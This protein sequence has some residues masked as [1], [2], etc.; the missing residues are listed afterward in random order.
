MRTASRAMPTRGVITYLA[1]ERHSSYGRDSIELLKVSVTSLFRYYNSHARD[2]MIFFH[3]GVSLSNRR[4]ILGL[5]TGAHAQFMELPPDQFRLPPGL[6]PQ[7]EW[8]QSRKFS[9]GYRHMIRFYTTGIWDLVARQGY[10]YVMRMDEDSVLWSPIRYNIFD[11]MAARGL[12]YGYRLASWEHGVIGSP[13]HSFHAFIRRYVTENHLP[14]GWLL[15]SC[16]SQSSIDGFT[17]EGCGEPYGAYNNLFVSRLAFWQRPDVRHYLEHIERSHKIYTMRWNDILWQSTAI[18]L[19]MSRERVHMFQDFAYEHTTFRPMDN[20]TRKG[21]CRVCTHCFS[22]GGIVLGDSIGNDMA[23]ATKRLREIASTWPCKTG[24]YLPRPCL[25]LAN[26]TGASVDSLTL[27]QVSAEQ[28]SCD[29]QPAPYYCTARPAPG[30]TYPQPAQTWETHACLCSAEFYRER[31]PGMGMIRFWRC[32]KKQMGAALPGVIV[33][34]RPEPA[35]R[36]LRRSDL[37]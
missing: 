2:D 13:F 18:K 31:H 32:Y 20:V 8:M 5:C 7:R 14:T 26:R 29:R 17:L 34:R 4:S 33:N 24:F 10:E 30:A 21:R 19:F 1:Q 3:T 11:F 35:L 15:D 12:E 9:A 25:R 36:G 37:A 6:P 28:P 22:W 16:V 23:E 27:G